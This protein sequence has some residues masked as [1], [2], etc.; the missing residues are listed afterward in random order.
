MQSRIPSQTHLPSRC[1]RNESI[2]NLDYTVQKKG[3]R[4]LWRDAEGR[5]TLEGENESSPEKGHF[6]PHSRLA[7]PQLVVK[8]L[9]S[10]KPF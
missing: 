4:Q 1:R 9:G 8:D 10:E 2:G 5:M 3:E 6:P 7:S